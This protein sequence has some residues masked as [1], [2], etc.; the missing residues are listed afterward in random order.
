[1]VG[2][3]VVGVVG[4]GD[5]GGGEGVNRLQAERLATKPRVATKAI[6]FL[7]E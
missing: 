1:M 6:T 7:L 2:A 4:V 3:G 5:G